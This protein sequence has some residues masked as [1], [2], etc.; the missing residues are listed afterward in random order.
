VRLAAAFAAA[1]VLMLAVVIAGDQLI[2]L[3]PATPEMTHVDRMHHLRL[4]GAALGIV[5]AVD[6]VFVWLALRHPPTDE[7]GFQ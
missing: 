5:I 2:G 7:Q 3:T 6:A 1:V 4:V